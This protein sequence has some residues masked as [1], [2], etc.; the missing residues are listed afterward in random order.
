MDLLARHQFNQ[1]GTLRE[2][3]SGTFKVVEYFNLYFTTYPKERAAAFCSM[4]GCDRGLYKSISEF[5]SC[6]SKLN[7][8]QATNG[9]PDEYGPKALAEY[10]VLTR[11]ASKFVVPEFDHGPFVIGHNDLTVQNILVLRL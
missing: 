9:L 5:Y 7:I 10:E 8:L 6:I 3:P 1:I 4:E 11:M 2:T